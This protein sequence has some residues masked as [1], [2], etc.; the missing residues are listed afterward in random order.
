[1]PGNGTAS[2]VC[3]QPGDTYCTGSLVCRQ[4][5]DGVALCRAAG[6]GQ[7]SSVCGSR[8]DVNCDIIGLACS[9]YGWFF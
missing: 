6:D 5:T 7:L 2:E 8:K 3:G 9:A 1:M 4:D